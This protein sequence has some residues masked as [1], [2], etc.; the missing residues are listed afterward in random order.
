MIDYLCTMIPDYR[1]VHPQQSLLNKKKQAYKHTLISTQGIH[2]ME[3][4][5]HCGIY[6]PQQMFFCLSGSV[7]AL[8]M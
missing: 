1:I 4:S 8:P 2:L 7:L 3:N 6:E 5:Y